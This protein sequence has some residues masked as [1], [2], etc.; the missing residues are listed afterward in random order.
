M[1]QSLPWSVVHEFRAL[2]ETLLELLHEVIAPVRTHLMMDL[3]GA[4]LRA[5]VSTEAEPRAIDK[6]AE[7]FNALST[8][9][10]YPTSYTFYRD[11]GDASSP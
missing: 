7:E 4:D 9:S 3:E 5:V 6:L 11:A 2:V 1:T 10:G 8:R